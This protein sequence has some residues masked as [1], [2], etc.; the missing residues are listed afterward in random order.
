MLKYQGESFLSIEKMIF[1][2][3]LEYYGFNLTKMRDGLKISRSTIYRQISKHGLDRYESSRH[4]LLVDPET[5]KESC[6]PK[7]QP[8]S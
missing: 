5:S 8:T 4:S 7:T 1:Q 2:Q 3:A 6:P